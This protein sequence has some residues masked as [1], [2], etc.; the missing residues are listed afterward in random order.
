MDP[1]FGL[2]A[3]GLKIAL[4]EHSTRVYERMPIQSGSFTEAYNETIRLIQG[5]IWANTIYSDRYTVLGNGT[6]IP[7]GIRRHTHTHTHTHG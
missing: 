4:M 7:P 1:I 3:A 6:G 5:V 2:A